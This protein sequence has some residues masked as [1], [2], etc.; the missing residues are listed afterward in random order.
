MSKNLKAMLER[1]LAQNTETHAAAKRDGGP[2]ILSPMKR[3][4]QVGTPSDGDPGR[5]PIHLIDPNPWQPRTFFPS[6]EIDDLAASIAEVGLI[7]PVAVRKIGERYQLIVGERRMR[8]HKVLGKPEISA[9]VVEASDD[10]VAVMSLAENI[11]REDLTDYEI[12][13]AIRKAEAT[14]PSR[15]KMAEAIGVPRVDFYRYLAFDALPDLAKQDLD[16]TPRILSR[17]AAEE[18]KQMLGRHK[19]ETDL[20]TLFSEL[21][22]Q[23]KAGTLDQTKFAATL[24]QAVKQKSL[25][26]TE[27]S[28][29]K[30]FV[31]KAQ[32]GSITK[33]WRSL[34]VKIKTQALSPEDEARLVGFVES[35][36]SVSPA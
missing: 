1:K 19:D 8:A 3:L 7:Q 23:L 13:K 9:Y 31:G 32:A 16:K 26:K 34:T 4:S 11:D 25:P 33:D 28:I 18:I 20:P 2:D 12:G 29:R 15:K 30:L 21:W 14:F 24:D 22:T 10:E 17:A 27:R 35:M 5:V 36:F 6:E